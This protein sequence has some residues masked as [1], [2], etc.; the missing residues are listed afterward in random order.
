MMVFSVSAN[1]KVNH[2]CSSFVAIASQHDVADNFNDV[3]MSTAVAGT[4]YASTAALQQASSTQYQQ[5]ELP[6]GND[7]QQLEL[8]PN[9]YQQLELRAKEPNYVSMVQKSNPTPSNYVNMAQNSG[10][11]YNVGDI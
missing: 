9:D 2:V 7:Y 8:R 3:P 6:S 4:N 5:I 1:V 10:P 11:D